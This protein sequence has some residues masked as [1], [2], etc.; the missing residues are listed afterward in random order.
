MTQDNGVKY[1][2]SL[3]VAQELMKRGHAAVATEE[4]RKT[5]GFLVWGF[6]K[7][8]KFTADLNEILGGMEK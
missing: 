5:R 6:R 4:S 8:S 3:R 2:R 1:I 7:S